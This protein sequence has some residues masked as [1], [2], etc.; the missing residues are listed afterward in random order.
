MANHSRLAIV[1]LLLAAAPFGCREDPLI[2]PPNLA[3][4]ADARV[5]RDGASI[6]AR[7]DGGSAALA[8]D[9]T[10]T[11]VAI[12]LDGSQSY[13]PDGTI[14]TYRWL[15]GTLQPEG[16]TPSPDDSGTMHRW[17]PPGEAP[18]WPGDMMQPQVSLGEGIWSFTLWVVDNGGAISEPDTIKI[19]IGSVVDPVV[20]KCADQVVMTEPAMCR[21][22]VCKQSDICRAAVTPDKCGQACW[23]L[24]NCVAA[25]CPDF[26]AMAAMGDYSCLTA[27]CAAYTGGSTGATPVA[28]CF[29]A[30]PADCKPVPATVGGGDGGSDASE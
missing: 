29:N 17:V 8:F 3:P 11:P 9:F 20:Q 24:I 27:N 6:N 22:C 16:G 12:T 5:I 26:T 18:N 15:S 4:V 21:Q 14:V 19:T 2:K 10:G 25:N 1:A 28:P 7:T 23:N 13:D 30:C